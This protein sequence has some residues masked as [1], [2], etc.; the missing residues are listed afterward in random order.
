MMRHFRRGTIS[1]LGLFASAVLLAAVALGDIEKPEAGGG[2]APEPEMEGAD[3]KKGSPS[4][5][6]EALNRKLADES[7]ANLKKIAER[8]DKIRGKLSKN[9]TGDATQ[10]DQR[11]VVKE[12]QELIDKVGK[13]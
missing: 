10:T 11:E 5:D 7:E 9:E 13:G 12:L 4:E 6:Q 3:G 2:V 1:A 8:M